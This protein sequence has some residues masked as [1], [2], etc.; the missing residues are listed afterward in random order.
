MT[1]RTRRQPDRLVERRPQGDRRR[2]AARNMPRRGAPGGRRRHGKGQQDARRRRGAESQARRVRP[3][4]RRR[5]AFDRIAEA[6][7]QRRVRGGG[8]AYRHDQR[9]RRD[10]PDRRRDFQ[11]DPR[12]PL[13]AAVAAAA[14]AWAGVEGVRREDERVRRARRRSRPDAML[15]SPYGHGGPVG[16]RHRRLHGGDAVGGAA[17]ARHRPRPLGRFG[18]CRAGAG[19]SRAHRPRPLQGRARGDHAQVERR[20]LELSRTRSSA[21]ATS[22]ASTPCP[23]TA[24]STTRRCFAS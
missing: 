22:S 24:W 2:H 1:I 18:P 9:R 11:R 15:P 14:L 6:L 3:R 12:R 4:L 17:A 21:S 10:N 13:H 7:S 23:A 5:L 20:R 19:L 16:A 8:G